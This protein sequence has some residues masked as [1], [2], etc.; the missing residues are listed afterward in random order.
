MT[1]EEGKEDLHQIIASQGEG[2]F[3]V[4]G[5]KQMN[6]NC[7]KE[8]THDNVIVQITSLARLKHK[9]FATRCADGDVGL[10]SSSNEP[11]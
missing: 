1:G 2:S 8:E 5:K 9:Y 6:Q 11:D 4:L 7:I 10:Y 3:F